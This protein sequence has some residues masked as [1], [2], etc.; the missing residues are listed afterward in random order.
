MPHAGCW[1]AVDL[2]AWNLPSE[3]A[4]A[5]TAPQVTVAGYIS[6]FPT[7]DDEKQEVVVTVRRI[8]HAGER[9]A[10][11]HE[12]R[13]LVV[14]ANVMMSTSDVATLNRAR[15]LFILMLST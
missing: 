15:L 12:V 7:V 3:D 10:V 14:D 2:A 9:G 6:N 8:R 5:R 1:T 11:W 4:F 13:R